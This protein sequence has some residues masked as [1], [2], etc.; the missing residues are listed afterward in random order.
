MPQRWAFPVTQAPTKGGPRRRFRPFPAAREI[1]S[2]RHAG[3]SR[4]PSFDPDRTTPIFQ[5]SASPAP[6]DYLKISNAQTFLAS[7]KKSS[8]WEGFGDLA[9][10]PASVFTG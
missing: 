6:Q 10:P 3:L 2:T 8:P 9:A 7:Q 1:F 4:P 5:D